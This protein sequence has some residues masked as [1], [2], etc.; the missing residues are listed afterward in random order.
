MLL[1]ALNIAFAVVPERA[2][3]SNVAPTV[4]K[5]NKYL[6]IF[7]QPSLTEV[8]SVATKLKVE[9]TPS[10]KFLVFPLML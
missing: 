10:N 2:I 5:V 9:S 4:E 3:R 6:I 7:G 8:L 1:E